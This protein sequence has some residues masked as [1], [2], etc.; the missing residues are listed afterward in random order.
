MPALAPGCRCAAARV[1]LRDRGRSGVDA[2]VCLVVAV[3][4]HITLPAGSRPIG[5]YGRYYYGWFKHGHRMLVG[6]FV[7]DATPAG[8]HIVTSAQAPMVLDGGC[9][10]VNLTYD[11]AR[12]K[13]TSLFCNGSG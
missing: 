1:G 12:K 13:V 2:L 10:V 9:S 4:A 7:L 6:V 5:A 8:V 11:P 3:E